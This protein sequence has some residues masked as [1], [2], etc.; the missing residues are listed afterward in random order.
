MLLFSSLRTLRQLDAQRVVYLR[1]AA[2]SV[3]AHL[4]TGSAEV[5]RDEQPGLLALEIISPDD[6]G[7]RAPALEAIWTGRELFRAEFTGTQSGRVFRVLVPFH[8]AGGMRIARIDLDPSAA[9]FLVVHARHNVWFAAVADVALLL[10]SGYAL[11]SAQ[12][13]SELERRQAAM[14]HLAHMGEMAAVLAHEIRNPLGTVKGYAQLIAERADEATGKMLAPILRET[15]RLESLA[16]DLLL[17]GHPPQ[18]SWREVAWREVAGALEACPFS[19]KVRFLDAG[20]EARFRTD[21]DLLR[22]I[23]MNLIRNGVE[24]LDG[25]PDGTVSVDFR[26]DAGAVTITV[27]DD[28]PGISGQAR[29]KLFQPFFTTKSYGTGLGLAISRT[30]AGLLGGTLG[31]LPGEPRGTRAVLRLETRV[32]TDTDC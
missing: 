28:G 10:L 29:E 17:Y 5:A 1:S 30:L 4:E 16:S 9:D 27:A 8:S 19:A 31:L 6:A 15:E 12:R 2:A 11:W 24:A 13:R 20:P 7:G 32:G 21:P 3:A 26:R 18:P 22:H 23:L 25:Q 14:E